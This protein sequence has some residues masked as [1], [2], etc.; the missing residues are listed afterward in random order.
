MDAEVQGAD[1]PQDNRP[2]GAVLAQTPREEIDTMRDQTHLG[3]ELAESVGK[4][5]A[6]RDHDVCEVGQPA[7][8]RPEDFEPRRVCH[9]GGVVDSVDALVDD[10]RGRGSRER[11]D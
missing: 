9:T 3:T 11:L 2:S 6:R 4:R 7:L 10:D 5:R 8:G 1:E